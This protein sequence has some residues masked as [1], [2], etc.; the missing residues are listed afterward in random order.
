M[1]KGTASSST[2]S[3]P[4]KASQPAAKA[5]TKPAAKSAKPKSKKLKLRIRV[6]S[7]EPTFFVCK[8]TTTMLKIKKAFCTSK[9]FELG[10]TRFV[11]DGDDLG[12]DETP[13]DLDMDDYEQ[14]DC[15][16]GV[17]E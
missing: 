8:T 6:G 11:F 7:T 12:D 14:I 5:T 17:P 10:T 16:V 15:I 9:G 1:V 4:A 2:F 13:G 3:A